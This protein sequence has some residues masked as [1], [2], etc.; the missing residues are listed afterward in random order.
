M[1]CRF[2]AKFCFNTFQIF[3]VL[4]LHRAKVLLFPLSKTVQRNLIKLIIR[5]HINFILVRKTVYYKFNK[6]KHSKVVLLLINFKNAS[7]HNAY[8]TCM[9][10]DRRYIL[11]ILKCLCIINNIGI[12]SVTLLSM[13]VTVKLN[14]S[15]RFRTLH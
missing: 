1:T 5:Q 7:I 15:I 11:F 3:A 13:N 4:C 6:T 9:Y 2:R 8:Y 14:K 12:Y 10:T